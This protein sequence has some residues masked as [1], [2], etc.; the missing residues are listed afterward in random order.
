MH[1]PNRAKRSRRGRSWGKTVSDVVVG[2]PT[3]VAAVLAS[4]LLR[5]R[6]NRWGVTDDELTSQ[7]PGDEL[8]TQPQLGY[9][10]AITI[11]APPTTVWP[12]LAQI[13]QGRGGLYSYDALE[14]LVGCNIHSTDQILDEHQ[15]LDIS[16]II[17]SGPDNYPCWMVMAIKPTEHLVLLGA[18]T[19]ADLSVPDTPPAV[20]PPKDDV[21]ATWQWQLRPHANRAQTRLLVRQ[22]LTYSPGQAVIWRLV[23]PINFAMEHKMLKGLKTRAESH[24]S[25]RA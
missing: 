16:D 12:W 4:P 5:R 1:R 9:T 24:P 22:R 19:P 25:A 2:A 18:G 14:N 21:A 20:T 13:G 10:R 15:Q 23:E 3:M 11:D 17:R 8:V 7:M 6:F